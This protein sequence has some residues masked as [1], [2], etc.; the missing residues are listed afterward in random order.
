MA[1]SE[2]RFVSLDSSIEEFLNQQENK[3]TLSKTRRDLNLLQKFLL[4][5]NERRSI[6]NIEPKHIVFLT[7]SD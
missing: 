2:A 3:N 6:E 7:L 4:T 1:D 5:R